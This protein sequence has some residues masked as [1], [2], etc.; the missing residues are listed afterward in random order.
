[1]NYYSKTNTDLLLQVGQRVQRNRLN[2][3]LTQ[4]ELAA[5]AGISRSSVQALE[6]GQ[7]IK[8]GALI[9]VLRALQCLDQMDDLF[10]DPEMSPLQ[11]AQMKGRVKQRASKPRAKQA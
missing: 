10:A 9:Q 11:L 4:G 3:N 6:S 7:G 8:L 1:M 5:Q 2:V